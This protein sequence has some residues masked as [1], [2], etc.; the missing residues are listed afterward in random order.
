MVTV[1]PLLAQWAPNVSL[2]PLNPPVRPWWSRFN[3]SIVQLNGS[4]IVGVRSANYRLTDA[5]RYEMDDAVIRSETV[6]VDWRDG[7]ASPPRPL[8]IDTD[9]EPSSFPVQ[10][11]EDVRL[12]AHEG[13]LHGLATVRDVDASGVCRIA[14]L[15]PGDAH[16]LREV[17]VESP[18]PERHEKNWAP[19]P[20][21]DGIRAVYSWDPLRVI[22][23]DSRSGRSTL[24]SRGATGL[25]PGTRGGSGAI[26]L[27]DGGSLFVVH[28]SH[29]L[30]SGRAYLHRFV[31]LSADGA[32]V[33]ASPRLRLMG[34]GVEF[35]AGAARHGDELL[36]TFGVGDREAWLAQVPL[37]AV[38]DRLRPFSPHSV[39]TT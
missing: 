22:T 21:T 20:G 33:S 5:G 17:L 27:D 3:P 38:L 23:I 14:L 29:H 15:V 30:P 25:G 32:L 37:Q 39:V 34:F 1:P 19:W 13:R 7:L 18:D 9:R 24:D 28:E 36:V 16:H 2:H 6:L 4:T 35:V 8:V 31:S 11:W 10:G 12:F 26:E